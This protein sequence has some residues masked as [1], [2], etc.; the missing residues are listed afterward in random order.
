M[1]TRASLPQRPPL[2]GSYCCRPEYQAETQTGR[3][4]VVPRGQRRPDHAAKECNPN[5]G[6]DPKRD[7]VLVMHG[8]PDEP[9]CGRNA[10]LIAMEQP[11]VDEISGHSQQMPATAPAASTL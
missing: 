6:N 2:A 4:P 1:N 7:G 3:K 9:P 8:G 11:A 5:R 10:G